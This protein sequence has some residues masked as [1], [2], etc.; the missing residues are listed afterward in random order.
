[1]R[2]KIVLGSVLG[3]VA[4]HVAFLAC[5]RMEAMTD[6]GVLDGLVDAMQGTVS[7]AHASDD[8][9]SGTCACPASKPA[10]WTFALRID[11]G[12]G[13]EEPMVDYSRAF[14]TG[15]PALQNGSPVIGLN[16][17]VNFYL[18]DQTPVTLNC[19]LN[20]RPDRTP[21]S[22]YCTV[23]GYPGAPIGQIPF[24][25]ALASVAVLTDSQAE[26]SLPDLSFS[27]GAQNVRIT[28]IVF[29]ANNSVGLVT[30][31]RDYRP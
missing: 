29:R 13:P 26:F 23:S 21:V 4:I 20:V 22:G 5:G 10:E 31:Q 25:A 28:G 8:G 12:A 9:G 2:G 30:P 19:T 1:M 14:V 24:Q 11:R 3:A 27:A 18:R 7:D 17:S 15:L 16:A 6:S